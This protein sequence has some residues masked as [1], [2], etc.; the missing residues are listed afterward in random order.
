MSSNCILKI[1][2]FH[3]CNLYLNKVGL[4]NANIILAKSSLNHKKKTGETT[5]KKKKQRS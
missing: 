5:I 1:G 2:E 4:K 3:V